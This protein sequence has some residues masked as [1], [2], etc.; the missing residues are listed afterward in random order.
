LPMAMILARVINP[1]TP[2][3]PDRLFGWLLE[4]ASRT[5]G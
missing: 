3:C 2:L 4:G 5:Q 1:D